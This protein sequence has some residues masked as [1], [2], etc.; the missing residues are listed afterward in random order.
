MKQTIKRVLMVLCVVFALFSLAG[1]GKKE[2]DRTLDAQTESILKEITAQQVEI[3]GSVPFEEFDLAIKEMEKQGFESMVVAATNA[4]AIIEENGAFVS[5]DE[6]SY[7]V[8]L[9]DDGYAVDLVAKFGTRDVDVH[10]IISEDI[11]ELLI[12]TFNTRYSTAEKMTK[13]GLNTLMGMGTVF[14]VLVFIIFI[15]S[16]FKY[17]NAWEKRMAEGT[18]KEAV[19]V[20][21]TPAPA[22]PAATENLVD[23]R[24]LAAVI[25]AAIAASENTSADGLVVRSIKRASES[26]WKR[27]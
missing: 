5:I 21:R 9:A 10:V 26:K 2:E 4:K 11:D 25:T 3:F 22:P 17:I 19:S 13:A 15:I 18:K 16:G 27:A 6:N 23:D 20:T 24:E 8:S 12:M 1:C 7:S 14:A